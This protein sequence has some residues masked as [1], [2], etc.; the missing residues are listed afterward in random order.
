MDF[1]GL[2]YCLS[3]LSYNFQHGVSHRFSRRI[4][5]RA[6][7]DCSTSGLPSGFCSRSAWTRR[8]DQ[9][10]HLP[11]PLREA[12]GLEIGQDGLYCTSDQANNVDVYS[13]YNRTATIVPDLYCPWT[14]SADGSKL[15][16]SH[17]DKAHSPQEWLGFL[18]QH[19]LF[20]WYSQ[21]SGEVIWHGE[22]VGDTGAYLLTN[23]HLEVVTFRQLLENYAK[24]IRRLSYDTS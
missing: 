12:I 14:V 17:P 20:P 18:L 6:T 9:I 21:A 11:D 10:K 2:G 15:C 19:F 8:I 4:S 1:F 3:A 7:V 23:N 22:D 5:T 16:S 24:E 13:N